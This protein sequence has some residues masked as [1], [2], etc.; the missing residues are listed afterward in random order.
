MINRY[1]PALLFWCACSFT[2][3]AGDVIPQ[4]K[5]KKI[6]E[7]VYALL[8]PIG[9]PSKDNRGYMVNSALIIGDQGAILVDT[10]FTDEIGR[11]IKSVIADITDKPV[12]HIINTHHHGDHTL[13]NSEFSGAQIISA[14]KCRDLVKETGYDWIALVENMTGY[15]FPN[16][17][18]VPATTVYAENT[19]QDVTL[20]GVAMRL[21]VPSGSHT[22]G[23]M[24]VYLPTH[25]ILISGDILVKKM[26][27]SFRDAYVKSWIGTLEQIQSVD[28]ETIIPGHGPL[29]SLADV[30]AMHRRMAELYAG[31]EAG[32]EKGLMDS[33][34]R[35]T[36]DLSEW[37]KMVE[38]E[39]L[40]GT[41]ISRTFLE[42]EQANF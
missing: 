8:G 4:P 7:Q 11:H 1:L 5:I 2:A 37:R 36:L 28:I 9:F 24:M 35:K 29:M 13:G 25:K 40:M 27:P 30:K 17:K 21:W 12:T 41:N 15:T 19:S 6:N 32:Y 31:V 42:V 14:K 22:P 38:F 23:D 16:T 34:I 18:P 26:M 39:G 3:S 20:Q 10:G 33:E